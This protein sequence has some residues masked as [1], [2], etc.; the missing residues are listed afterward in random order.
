MKEEE[1]VERIKE[2]LEHPTIKISRDNNIEDVRISL[3]KVLTSIIETL[4]EKS[5]ESL[6]I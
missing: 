6:K 1:I 5:L 4:K 2:G 3:V